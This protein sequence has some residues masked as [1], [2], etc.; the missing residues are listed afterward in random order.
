ML[1]ISLLLLSA[2]GRA[3]PT[4]ADG[5]A[6][7]RALLAHLSGPNRN[8]LCLNLT[9]MGGDARGHLR[10]HVPPRTL[11]E[12]LRPRR[13]PWRAADGS[14]PLNARDSVVLSR[15]FPISGQHDALL[16]RIEPGDLPAPLERR[17]GDQWSQ[18]STPAFAGD[19][20]FISLDYHC[21]EWCGQ[22]DIFALR[23]ENG[24]WRV[25]GSTLGW[26]S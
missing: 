13:I 12:I 22:G 24:Q 14:G 25:I 21:G 26:I 2:C 20:A 6:A 19:H 23:R 1:L 4:P 8:P 15:A 7:I 17:C 9:L 18:L 16:R 3:V 5:R 10:S 11:G